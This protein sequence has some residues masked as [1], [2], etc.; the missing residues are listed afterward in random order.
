MAVEW[1]WVPCFR[2][3]WVGDGQLHR[4]DF[5]TREAAETR[6]RELRGALKSPLLYE[7]GGFEEGTR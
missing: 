2:V 6:E 4:E 3:A 5:P 1:P 7:V